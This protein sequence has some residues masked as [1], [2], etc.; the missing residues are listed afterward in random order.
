M[1][2]AHMQQPG[3]AI[4]KHRVLIS[5]PPMPG[6]YRGMDAEAQA[7]QESY[8]A[9]LKN[10]PIP[11]KYGAANTTPLTVDVTA[12]KKTYEFSLSRE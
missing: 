5:D 1:V 3:A 6:E 8:L 4:A 2:C 11:P 7:K 10:R 9:G 12:D